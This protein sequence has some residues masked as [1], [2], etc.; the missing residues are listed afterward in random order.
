VGIRTSTS[1]AGLAAL[2]KPLFGA[3]DTPD[4]PFTIDRLTKAL[5]STRPDAQSGPNAG[6]AR[7][8]QRKA[9]LAARKET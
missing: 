5:G 8:A 2:G 4:P 9:V 1:Q 6:A 7:T 3:H